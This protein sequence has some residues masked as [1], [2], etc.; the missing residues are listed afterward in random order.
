MRLEK[1]FFKPRNNTG[2]YLHIYNHIT[3][4][5]ASPIHLSKRDQQKIYQKNNSFKDIIIGS[6]SKLK[7]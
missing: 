5:G 1:A 6:I 4:M 2:V 7:E 3:E